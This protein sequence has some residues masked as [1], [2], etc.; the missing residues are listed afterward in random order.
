MRYR[1]SDGKYYN[2]IAYKSLENVY[3]GTKEVKIFEKYD[4]TNKRYVEE[5]ILL[6]DIRRKVSRAPTGQCEKDNNL[7][8]KEV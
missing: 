5:L 1:D 8:L 3:D 6:F 4:L 7:L 2:R